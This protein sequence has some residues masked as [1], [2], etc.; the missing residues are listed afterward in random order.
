MKKILII[1]L[2]GFM[3]ACASCEETPNNTNPNQDPSLD[4]IDL[5]KYELPQT[6]FLNDGH[7]L[8]SFEE[9]A[10]YLILNGTFCFDSNLDAIG[11]RIYLKE[12]HKVNDYYVAFYSVNNI[13]L[14][15]VAEQEVEIKSYYGTRKQTYQ[16]ITY[17]KLFDDNSDK[18]N[19]CYKLFS[20]YGEMIS[21]IYET[22]RQDFKLDSYVGDYILYR[23][24]DRILY[25][26]D[27]QKAQNISEIDTLFNQYN[28]IIGNENN[29]AL[30]TIGFNNY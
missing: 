29:I 22:P 3:L 4:G 8:T 2:I 1:L 16:A 6:D 15:H 7:T 20:S 14:A 26:D 24:S 25:D 12:D 17:V 11:Y 19:I 30:S 23:V 10:K 21:T 13:K 5:D 9:M 28:Q 18:V 27:M